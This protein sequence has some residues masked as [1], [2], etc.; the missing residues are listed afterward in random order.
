MRFCLRQAGRAICR[1][2]EDQTAKKDYPLA[3]TD[4]VA[5][6]NSALPSRFAEGAPC[7]PKCRCYFS[8]ARAGAGA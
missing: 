2:N 8:A 4:A 7:P 6:L 3:K 1:R 5:L